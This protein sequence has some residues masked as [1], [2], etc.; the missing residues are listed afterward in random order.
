MRLKNRHFRRSRR[1]AGRRQR[2][3]DFALAAGILLLSGTIAVRLSNPDEI[4]L[5]AN[6]YVIDGDTLKV[7]RQ[8]VRLTGLDAPELDQEC[9]AGG[10]RYACGERARHFLAELVSGHEVGCN[11][12]EYDRYGRLLAVC[13][14]AGA[15][16]NALMVANGWAV[17]YG[18]YHSE[19]RVARE[20]G[21]GIWAGQFDWPEDWRENGGIPPE[22]RHGI[23]KGFSRGVR[24][25]FGISDD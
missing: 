17:A 7:D 15:D 4:R 10:Q 19:E 18:G 20:G 21:L 22:S 16:L 23:L 24:R 6:A 14:A 5:S 2:I 9:T 13:N 12:K 11:G 1:L 3:F 25:L 8:R